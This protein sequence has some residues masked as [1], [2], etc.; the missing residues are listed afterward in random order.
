MLLSSLFEQRHAILLSWLLQR[1]N[2]LLGTDCISLVLLQVAC[3]PDAIL[4]VGA[5]PPFVSLSEADAV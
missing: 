2:V 5:W 1:G 3:A 4:R